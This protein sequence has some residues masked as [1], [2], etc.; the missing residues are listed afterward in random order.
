MPTLH[1]AEPQITGPLPGPNARAWL[2]RDEA[3]TS[4]SYTRT[5]PLVV[6]RGHGCIIEDVD[7][8]HFLDMT[9]GIAV[10]N[11]GHCHPR[12]TAAVRRQAGELVHMS[13]TDFY[14]RPQI[15]LAERLAASMPGPGRKRVFFSN[16]GAEANEAALKLARYHT[17][18]PRIIAFFGAFHGR[19]YGAMS[20]SGSKS[21]QRRGFSPLLSDIHHATYGNLDS[22]HA[23]LKTTCPP[24]EL[25]AI[26]V[27][28]IQGEGGYIV[29]PDDF[30]PGLRALCDKVGALLVLDEVQ[31]GMGRTGKLFAHEHWGIH[32]DVICLA[33]GIA[34][35]LPL[36]AIV[37][38]EEVMDW[39]PGS[40]ASTFGGNPVACA[41]ALTVL[42]LL[43]E[44]YLA[45]AERR[46]RQ[47][48]AGLKALATEHAVIHD[49]RGKG[50]M[51]GM[52]VR[53]DGQ[54][55][56]DFRDRIIDLAFER[57]LLLLPCGASTVRFCP[58]L[59]LTRRQVE[60]GLELTDAALRAASA[61]P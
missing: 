60:I 41:S 38:R 34:N 31:S 10:T 1:R 29:P 35:G 3:V 46:G 61:T 7:G 55:D 11:V 37:T 21:L 56:G 32:A 15:E 17:K 12:V 18:R 47:L 49:V 44:K 28:P 9:A 16:S 45:N 40:H 54:P 24:E 57:G 26:F 43:E 14:Y 59:C 8:N 6:K 19:T 2:E 53:R 50:L 4:P 42:D 33:K 39:V 52:E 20:L 22:V 48:M 30:L 23:L 36:G 5:Y 13:G 27:E 51:V 25:A 58:P